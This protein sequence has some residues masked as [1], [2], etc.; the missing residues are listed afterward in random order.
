LISNARLIVHHFFVV[1]A[2]V[3]QL[4]SLNES[5]DKLLTSLNSVAK[6]DSEVAQAAARYASSLVG[7]FFFDDSNGDSTSEASAREELDAAQVDRFVC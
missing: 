4:Q 5:L 1:L 2:N 7:F 6:V 3:T